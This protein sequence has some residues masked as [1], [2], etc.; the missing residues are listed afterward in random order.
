MTCGL[1][2]CPVWSM[3]CALQLTCARESGASTRS[4]AVA[5][6]DILNFMCE[7]PTLR[8]LCVDGLVKVKAEKKKSPSFHWGLPF[9]NSRKRRPKL[10]YEFDSRDSRHTRHTPT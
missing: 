2:I 6:N 8:L 1:R 7:S 5:S 9:A 4:R 10:E 3:I